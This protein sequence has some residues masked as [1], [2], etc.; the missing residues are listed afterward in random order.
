MNTN[1]IPDDIAILERQNIILR[2]AQSALGL[3]VVIELVA[4]IFVSMTLM[5]H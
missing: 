1:P 4:I 3:S 5:K 2:R